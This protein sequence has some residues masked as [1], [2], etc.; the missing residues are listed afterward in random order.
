MT[1][2]LIKRQSDNKFQL[3]SDNYFDAVYD[4][5]L[6]DHTLSYIHNLIDEAHR[7]IELAAEPLRSWPGK[8]TYVRSGAPC[9][10]SR[11]KAISTV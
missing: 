11:F 4:I 2:L 5:E 1:I 7:Q 6:G 8:S 9:G 3:I 10:D